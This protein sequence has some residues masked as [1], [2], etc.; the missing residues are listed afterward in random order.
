MSSIETA[1]PAKLNLHLRVGD[2]RGDGF[3]DIESLFVAL[4][5]GDTLRVEALPDA[6][7]GSAEVRMDWRIPGA[8]MPEPRLDS[9]ENIVSRAV[10]LF[11]SRSGYG[12]AIRVTVEKRIPLGGGLGGGS[13][14]AAAALLA[15]NRLAL[16]GKNQAPGR[17]GLFGA[18]AIAEMGAEL[19]SDVPFFAHG[20]AAALV[21]GRGERVRPIALPDE[22]LELSLLLVNPGFP[23][24]TAAAFRRLDEHRRSARPDAHSGGAR[25]E[26]LA[27]ALAGP[28]GSWPFS[29]DFLPAFGARAQN[30]DAAAYA[31]IISALIELG[32]DF[33]S[34]SGSGSTCFGVFSRKEKA[35]FAKN[36]LLKRWPSVLET[37]CLRPMQYVW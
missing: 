31:Q 34:L 37:F 25:L 14:D 10:S 21:S 29:N 36:R 23:S 9:G 19:G 12:E 13:S 32:A 4:D 30:G 28:P 20:A 17:R 27:D 8:P 6:P 18:E 16:A 22:A 24:D 5:F 7:A 2:R 26:E 35:E 3:H 33:A 15:L 11:R 1:A